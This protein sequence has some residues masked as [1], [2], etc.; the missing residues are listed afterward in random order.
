MKE[1]VVQYWLE[2]LFGALIA[3]MGTCY[4]CLQRRVHKQVCD[5]QAIK[6]GT[7][8]LLR[9]QIIHSYDKYINR[10]WI[11][12]YAMDNVNVMYKAYHALGG[13]GTITKII[14]ELTEL[15]STDPKDS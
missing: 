14:E 8:A 2:C 9:N 6:D 1:F 7:Q 13:N 10:K 15:P 11:P 5:Q 4:R 3:G 12:I